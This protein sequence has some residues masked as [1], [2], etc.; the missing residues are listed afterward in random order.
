MNSHVFV[1]A[2][3]AFF[4]VYFVLLR[5]LRALRS[6]EARNMKTLGF[7]VR[8][9]ADLGALTADVVKTMPI[10]GATTFSPRLG[11]ALD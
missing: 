5:T 2:A 6:F 9:E 1:L 7:D 3:L 4:A 11:K 8:S 10:V